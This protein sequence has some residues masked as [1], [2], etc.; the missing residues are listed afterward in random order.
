MRQC[1]VVDL[2]VELA[3][4]AFRVSQ[5][6]ASD[7]VEVVLGQRLELEDAAA[8][9]QRAVDA[10]IGVLGG[11][12]DQH[13]R[14]VLYVRQQGVLL[15][16]VEAMHLVHE[17]DGF[18]AIQAALAL[19][20]VDGFANVL[21]AGQHCVER[22]EMGAG[23]VGDDAR[24]GGLAGARWAIEDHTAELVGLDGAPQQASRSNDVVLADI[25]VQRARPHARGQRLFAGDQ[26]LTLMIKK[27]GACH[28]SIVA[29]NQES[30]GIRG[31]IGK[32][33]IALGG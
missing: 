27:V 3:V 19:G 1:V 13:H 14:A 17:E 9:D 20:C 6:L 8:A 28:A 11:R 26:F 15:R 5:R 25:L 30:Q 10:E 23:G 18:A 7:P 12:A 29:Q 2:D 21:D 4:A 16:L 24:Q 22:D 33:Q 31:G 32:G